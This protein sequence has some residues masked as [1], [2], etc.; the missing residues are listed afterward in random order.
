MFKNINNLFE[1][2]SIM[3]NF[4][5]FLS[6]SSQFNKKKVE[7][8]LVA[9]AYGLNDFEWQTGDRDF[10][11]SYDF[12][13][14]DFFTCVR[15]AKRAADESSLDAIGIVCLEGSQLGDDIV[16]QYD[17]KKKKWSLY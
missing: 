16:L 17:P 9:I 15:K 6:E 10:G 11:S 12:G 4:T 7:E 13:E 5:A 8:F 14:G 1:E 2:K 3:K